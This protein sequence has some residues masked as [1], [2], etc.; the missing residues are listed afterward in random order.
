[1][2]QLEWNPLPG[3]ALVILVIGHGAIHAGTY[4]RT[5]Q[6]GFGG[7]HGTRDATISRNHADYNNGMQDSFIT[8]NSPDQVALVKFVGLDLP[9]DAKI[10]S[11]KLTLTVREIGNLPTISAYGLLKDFTEGTKNDQPA[12]DGETTWN[13]VRHGQQSWGMPGGSDSSQEFTYNGHA[14]RHL[15]ADDQITIKTGAS[16]CTWDVTASLASQVRQGKEYGW[17]LAVVDTKKMDAFVVFFSRQ[18]LR[19]DAPVSMFPKLTVTFESKLTD[20]SVAPS[21]G[22]KLILYSGRHPSDLRGDPERLEQFPFD[23]ISFR[24]STAGL[25]IFQP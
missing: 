7:Y 1:M 23:G 12:A 4:T 5:F 15:P 17:A 3:L 14:D 25:Q 24:A 10:V 2:Q 21:T 11:A 22:A 20:L 19:D 6:N 9:A 8:R 18:W 13:A 16:H